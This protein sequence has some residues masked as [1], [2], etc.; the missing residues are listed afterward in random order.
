MHYK[1]FAR[2]PTYRELKMKR[3]ALNTWKVVQGNVDDTSKSIEVADQDEDDTGWIL[4][5]STYNAASQRISDMYR[6]VVF[7]NDEDLFDD[8]HHQTQHGAS[9]YFCSFNV[10]LFFTDRRNPDLLAFT[11]YQLPGTKYHARRRFKF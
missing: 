5:A 4:P 7:G 10:Y 6:N 11:E 8:V 9:L 1:I 3:H 2:A